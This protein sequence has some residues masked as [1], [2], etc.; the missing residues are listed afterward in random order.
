MKT[1]SIV[2]TADEI[3]LSLTVAQLQKITGLMGY[4]D[5]SDN[6]IG[7]ADLYFKL[8]TF[9]RK[10]FGVADSDVAVYDYNDEEFDFETIKFS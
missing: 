2:K 7:A 9:L 1:I 10:E 6:D 8:Q 5:T 3:Q 4:V